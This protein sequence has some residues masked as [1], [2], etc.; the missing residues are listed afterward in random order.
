MV[1]H[2]HRFQACPLTKVAGLQYDV[3]KP[4]HHTSPYSSTNLTLAQEYW[5]TINFDAG[6]IYITDDM[7]ESLGLPPAQP[8][9][10]D[11]SHSIYLL[12]GHHNLHC[13]VSS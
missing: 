3:L 10:W 4:F 12:N 2:S 5:D 7:V 8:F 13:L 9:P 6:M 11:N 1:S